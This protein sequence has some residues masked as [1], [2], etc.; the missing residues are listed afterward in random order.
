NA[1][2]TASDAL[3]AGLP[4]ITI[5]GSS[6]A[7]RVASSLLTAVGLEELIVTSYQEYEELALNL[8]FNL[9]ALA[10]IKKQLNDNRLLSS[11]FDT[12]FYVHHIQVAY[13]RV[14]EL[15]KNGLPSSHIFIG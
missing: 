8:A 10:L 9:S 14:Y 4:L 1:H 15:Y 11:L 6:F 12:P 3:W 5:Q 13:D 2:T 7:S